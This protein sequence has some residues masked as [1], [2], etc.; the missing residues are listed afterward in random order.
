MLSSFND[1]IDGT[2]QKKRLIPDVGTL[3]IISTAI[4]GRGKK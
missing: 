1:A 3:P 2:I 4:A